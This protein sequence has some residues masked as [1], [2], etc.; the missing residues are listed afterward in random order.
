MFYKIVRFV[1]IIATKIF[2]RPKFIGLDNI[3]KDGSFIFA[4]NHTSMFDPVP[5][6]CISKRRVHF[7]AKKELFKFPQS[8]IF[9]HLE[10][11]PVKRDNN[12]KEA[13][14]TAINYLKN[15]SIVGIYPEGTRERGRGLLDFKYGTIK[16]AKETDCPIIPVGISGSYN[17]FKNDL[18]FKFERPIYIK[19]VNKFENEKVKRIIKKMI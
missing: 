2:F 12:D 7:L 5:I 17:I 18:C 13:L 8:I 6:I 11:I 9:S 10:L 3:P 1:C 16:M 15:G 14:D 19:N 4:S